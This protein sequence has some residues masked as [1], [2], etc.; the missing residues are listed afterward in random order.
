MTSLPGVI[1]QA[2]FLGLTESRVRI[3]S[4]LFFGGKRAA[5]KELV[6]VETLSKGVRAWILL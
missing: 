5:E 6:R 3:V 1:R 4:H 2:M